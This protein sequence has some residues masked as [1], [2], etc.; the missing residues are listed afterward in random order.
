MKISTI[1][2]FFR[3]G[4]KGVFDNSTMSFA[5]VSIISACVFMTI[6]SYCIAVN[7]NHNMQKLE[8]TGGITV[9]LDNELSVDEISE[10][11][12]KI[13][14]MPHTLLIEYISP[15]QALLEFKETLGDKKDM[16]IGLEGDSPLKP[17]FRIQVD[18][19]VFMKEYINIVKDTA[20]V[21]KVN[22]SLEETEMLLSIGN[23]V[24]VISLVIIAIL[25][26]VS[27]IIVMNTIK[28]TVSARRNEIGIMKYV[29]STDWFIRFPF[30]IEG[31]IIGFIGAAFPAVASWFG[32]NSAISFFFE[33]FENLNKVFTFV[34][35]M[36]IFPTLIPIVLGIGI[37]IGT[38]GSLTS[39]RRFL[40]V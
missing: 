40:R 3:E 20:G 5:S 15:E 29:G 33:R 23:A 19:N 37:T 14:D 34:D 17:S 39:I 22:H 6:F 26:L 32:Y 27:I 24:R 8:Q 31:L 36:V 4:F 35:G 21:R 11:F 9:F 30:I 2:F 18:D 10:V 12:F 16:L 25:A 13:R 7:L 28:M 38:I 1:R